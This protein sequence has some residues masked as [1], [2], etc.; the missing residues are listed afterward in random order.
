MG[1]A[2][3]GGSLMKVWFSPP[4]CICYAKLCFISKK[5]TLLMKL[6]ED[7]QTRARVLVNIPNMFL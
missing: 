2:D 7:A 3:V 5:L 1:T 6:L 4:V